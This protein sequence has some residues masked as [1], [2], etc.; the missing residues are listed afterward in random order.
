MSEIKVRVKNRK[1]GKEITFGEEYLPV[2]FPYGLGPTHSTIEEEL[3]KINVAEKFNADMVKDNTIGRKEH[4]ELLKKVRERTTL[5]VGASATI[6]AANVAFS[7]E[8][9]PRTNPTEEDFY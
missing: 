7:R 3:Y 1:T 8:E 9:K 5:C 2:V 4:L 6:T